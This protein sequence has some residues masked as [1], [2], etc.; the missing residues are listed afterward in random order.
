MCLP[1]CVLVLV[2]VLLT[3]FRVFLS[4]VDPLLFYLL[5]GVPPAPF[6]GQLPSC[7]SYLG[8]YV[9]FL[10]VQRCQETEMFQWKN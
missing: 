3:F 7:P 9:H 5:P 1:V 6:R 2:E 8:H 4:M 10:M